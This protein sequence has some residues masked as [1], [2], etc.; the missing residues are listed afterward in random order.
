[1]RRQGRWRAQAWAQGRWAGRAW[2][3]GW[4]SLGLMQPV[5]VLTW[6]FDSV[7]FLSHRLDSVHEHCSLQKNFSEKKKIKYFKFK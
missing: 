7:V 1:M 5:W 2:C 3:T 4:A 6:V